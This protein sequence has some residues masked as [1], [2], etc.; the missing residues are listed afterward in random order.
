MA[1]L[2]SARKVPFSHTSAGPTRLPSLSPLK[3]CASFSSGK[4]RAL[5][6]ARRRKAPLPPALRSGAHGD[7]FVCCGRKGGFRLDDAV[8][9]DALPLALLDLH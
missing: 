9:R 6:A 3:S 4:R 2:P 5:E 8:C 7:P 1:G